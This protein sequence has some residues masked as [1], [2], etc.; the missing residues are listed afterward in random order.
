MTPKENLKDTAE[1]GQPQDGGE[2]M[3]HQPQQLHLSKFTSPKEGLKIVSYS[4]HL[5]NC[6]LLIYSDKSPSYPEGQCW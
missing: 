4:G 1:L 2:E 6:P 5:E 3:G